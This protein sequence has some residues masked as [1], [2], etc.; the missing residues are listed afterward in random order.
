MVPVVPLIALLMISVLSLPVSL[1]SR[2]MLPLPAV[3]TPNPE[4]ATV[5]V[6]FS[7]VRVLVPVP[8]AE[9]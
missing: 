6:P 3:L 9:V 7:V 8:T 2:V 1:A 4:A 5:M